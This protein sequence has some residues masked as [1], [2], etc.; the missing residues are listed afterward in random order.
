MLMNKILITM[1]LLVTITSVFAL[2]INDVST[3]TSNFFSSIFESIFSFFSVSTSTS[4]T[5]DS[6]NTASCTCS[7]SDCG[8]GD[9]LIYNNPD[10]LSFP[11]HDKE[12]SSNGEITWTPGAEGT[13]GFIVACA[14]DMSQTDCVPITVEGVI[15]TTTVIPET[16]TTLE[17]TTTTQSETTTTQSE[18]TTTPEETTTTT[19]FGEDLEMNFVSCSENECTIDIVKNTLDSQLV[20]FFQLKEDISGR[21]Y[22]ISNLNIEPKSTGEKKIVITRVRPCP[23]DT[24]VTFLILTYRQT[25][26]GYI[27]HMLRGD[28]FTC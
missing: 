18:T 20:I 28:T 21:I 6:C 2:S 17:E 1:M 15:V 10:C 7:I 9:V 27:L 19:P 13:Y 12:F 5:C 11:M 26:L 8:S 14:D 25:N 22:Y 3:G 4:I 23:E 24:E 16:T